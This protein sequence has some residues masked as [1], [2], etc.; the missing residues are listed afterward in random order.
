MYYCTK[1]KLC[2]KHIRSHSANLTGLINLIENT[3]DVNDKQSLF[4]ML[5]TSTDK[6]EETIQNLNE[7]ISI[8]NNLNQAKVKLNL[9]TEIERTFLVVQDV[10]L[11]SQVTIENKVIDEI[12]LEVIPAYLDSI[13]LNLITNAIKYRSPERQPIIEIS[14]KTD[15]DYLVLLV[16]DNGLGLDLKKFKDKIFGMYKTFHNNPNSRGIGLFITKNQ[17]EAM[18][19][20]I[21]VESEVNVGTTFKIYFPKLTNK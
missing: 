12:N 1:S 5:K 7:I 17:I 9:K 2:N 8:Q 3:D 19:G 11:E 13:L 14:T 10:I 4:K 6:L 16:K 18:N 20:K 21:E 15:G